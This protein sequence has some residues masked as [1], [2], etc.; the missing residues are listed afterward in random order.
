LLT[1]IEALLLRRYPVLL[2]HLA[3][4]VGLLAA[5]RVALAGGWF[6]WIGLWLLASGV[7]HGMALR[8]Q[9]SGR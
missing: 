9:W 3:A 2:W 4:G 6:G 7:A 8:G 5:L 1:A